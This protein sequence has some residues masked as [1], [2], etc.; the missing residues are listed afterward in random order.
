MASSF[1]V[2]YKISA[3]VEAVSRAR[4]QVLRLEDQLHTKLATRKSLQIRRFRE[5]QLRSE[6]LK[7]AGC[8]EDAVKMREDLCRLNEEIAAI[9]RIR[10]TYVKYIDSKCQEMS[11]LKRYRVTTE[12]DSSFTELVVC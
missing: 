11:V 2:S 10:D 12:H 7:R 1:G 9:Q 5:V 4:I 3:L 8:G 6:G